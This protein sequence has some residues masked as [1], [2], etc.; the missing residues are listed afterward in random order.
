MGIFHKMIDAGDFEKTIALNQS[1][2]V[3]FFNFT[4]CNISSLPRMVKTILQ[5][6]ASKDKP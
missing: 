1:K 3:V 2:V 4:L 6:K 5:R